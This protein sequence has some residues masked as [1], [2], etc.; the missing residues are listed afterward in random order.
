MGVACCLLLVACCLLLMGAALLHSNYRYTTP[1]HHIH[2]NTPCLPPRASPPAASLATST[3]ALPRAPSSRLP[4][5]TPTSP[6]PRTAAR[7]RRSSSFPTSSDLSS[8]TA[9]SS[10]TSTPHRAFTYAF[11][12][13]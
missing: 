5:S 6:N 8:L 7:Q 2:S 12:T 1:R 11:R 3:R 13:S 9:V 10:R 4:A